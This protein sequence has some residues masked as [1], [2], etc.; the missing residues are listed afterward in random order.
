MNSGLTF[1]QV[2]IQKIIVSIHHYTRYWFP[3]WSIPSSLAFTS[4]H[5][6]SDKRQNILLHRFR[7]KLWAIYSTRNWKVILPGCMVFL[8]IKNIPSYYV[9]SPM[10]ASRARRGRSRN[11]RKGGMKGRHCI[12]LLFN[13]SKTM[14][15]QGHASLKKFAIQILRIVISSIFRDFKR[16]RGLFAPPK[17]AP[18]LAWHLWYE[19]QPHHT[20]MI[21]MNFNSNILANMIQK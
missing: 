16:G 14:G 8:N 19:L 21:L 9:T 11:L 20:E 12:H 6:C 13:A 5:C 7:W 1:R 18:A 17:S 10:M 4:A 15:F 2:K 3:S